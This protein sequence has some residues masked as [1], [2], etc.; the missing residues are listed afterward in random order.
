M[1]TKTNP[2]RERRTYSPDLNLL[3]FGLE[4]EDLSTVFSAGEV[5]GIGPST[6]EKIIIIIIATKKISVP[7]NKKI[8]NKI[9][10]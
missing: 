2:V 7:T 8:N 4:E 10:Q 5:M 1:F 3:N 6:L 9:K